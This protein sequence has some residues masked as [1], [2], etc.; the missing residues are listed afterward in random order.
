M[1]RKSQIAIDYCYAFKEAHPEAHVFWVYGAVSHLFEQ[2]YQDIAKKARI[3]GCDDQKMDKLQLV[4]EWLQSTDSKEWLMAV[5]NADDAAMFY[6]PKRSELCASHDSSKLFARFLPR[7]PH[8]RVLITTRDRRL[9]DR[10]SHRGGTIQ[11]TTLGVEE[12][13]DLLK[14]KIS[15]ANRSEDDVLKLVEY[16]SYLPLAITQAAAFISENS[17][18]VSEYLETLL[19]NESEEKELLSEHLEDPRR[20]LSSENSV[21]RTWRLSFA[22]ISNESP[23]AAEILSLL[24]VLDYNGTPWSLLRNEGETETGFRTA[25]G[26]L[27]A[28]SLITVTKG[29]NAICKIHRLVALATE[30]WLETRRTISYWQS[31]ALTIL[32]KRFP[33]PGQQS[34]LEFANMLALMPHA[35]LVLS[36][37]FKSTDEMLLC[38]R[39]LISTALFDLSSARY[40]QAFEKCER[41]LVIREDLLPSDHPETVESLQT[42]GEALLHRGELRVAKAT[43]QRA[44]VGREKSLGHLHVDT[45]ESL[46]DLTITL[47]ELNDLDS[48]EKT[49]QEAL[50]GR[51]EVFGQNH[52]DYL[53]SLNIIAILYQLKGDFKR[54]LEVT[55]R[56]LRDREKLLGGECPETLMTLNNLARLK[57]Q[58]GDLDTADQM[59]DRVLAGEEAA[60]AKN[61]YDMQ[62]SLRNKAQVLV[63][64]KWFHEAEDVFRN[65]LAMQE[66]AVGPLHPSTLSTMKDL[67]NVLEKQNDPKA[68]EELRNKIANFEKDGLKPGEVGALF[69]AGLLF[70]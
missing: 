22:Q 26:I 17:M 16:L 9:G 43:L 68:A 47:L 62:V 55:E 12:S 1:F 56:V 8:G 59:L 51:R 32:T 49:G 20:E 14:S 18:T 36:Y 58:I 52:P 40:T 11:V 10:L 57:Y 46:S 15:E 7:C 37:Q 50:E 44:I 65:V 2:G 21:V 3:P 38:A 42:L 53:V 31:R 23:C 70:D 61:G 66:K 69:R 54:A 33:G 29:H 5:D 45:L 39:L 25:L 35:Q 30:R 60:L 27:Q 4:Y 24:A 48:A 6:G 28:F 67:V 64:R 63:A 34:Y 19:H 41:S 13:K